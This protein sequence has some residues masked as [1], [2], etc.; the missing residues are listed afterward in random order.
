LEES[1][2]DGEEFIVDALGDFEPMQRTEVRSDVVVFWN[3][4]DDASEV[5]LD[6]LETS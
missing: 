4:A 3:S 5:I 6:E 1:E 2:G